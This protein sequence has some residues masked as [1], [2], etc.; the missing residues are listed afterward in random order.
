MQTNQVQ[1][2]NKTKFPHLP[3]NI[4]LQFRPN[5][6]HITS[7]I[8]TP[9][10]LPTDASFRRCSPVSAGG[11]EWHV[12]YYL[13]ISPNKSFLWPLTHIECCRAEGKGV[14]NYD[15]CCY[16]YRT[17]L[18]THTQ[19]CKIFLSKCVQLPVTAVR[20][21]S[22]AGTWAA[23]NIYYLRYFAPGFDGIAYRIV[24]HRIATNLMEKIK[25]VLNTKFISS[26][27]V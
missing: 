22:M 20:W 1:I 24:R 3:L 5:A 23:N 16:V 15:C 6:S 9:L 7:S 21:I 25:Q 4:H 17:Y 10:L 14:P 8:L 13:N 19:S 2:G 27:R 26:F 18:N 11:I 12:F